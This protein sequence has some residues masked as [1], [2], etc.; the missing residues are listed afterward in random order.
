MSFELLDLLGPLNHEQTMFEVSV[1]RKLQALIGGG[2]SVP[3]GINASLSDGKLIIHSAFG[4]E[5][6]ELLVKQRLDGRPDDADTLI[7]AKPEA[8]TGS[9]GKAGAEINR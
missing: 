4:T 6:G 1:E 3:L 5:E 8:H 9:A 7:A 2:C